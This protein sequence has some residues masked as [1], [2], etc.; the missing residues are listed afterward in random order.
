VSAFEKVWESP[1]GSWQSQLIESW[2]YKSSLLDARSPLVEEGQI[3]EYLCWVGHNSSMFERNVPHVYF[4]VENG[5]MPVTAASF[6]TSS[7]CSF[8]EYASRVLREHGS[9]STLLYIR[10]PQLQ[11]TRLRYEVESLLA[12]IWIFGRRWQ[13]LELEIYVGEYEWTKIGIHREACANI[14]QVI[15]GEK[16]M[17]VWPPHALL[18]REDRPQCALHGSFEEAVNYGVLDRPDCVRIK[19]AAGQAIYIPSAYWHVGLSKRFSVAVNLCL[20]GTSER[21]DA[22]KYTAFGN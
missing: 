18:P 13:H 21:G 14:H 4:A 22:S 2:E 10:N 17:L 19:A 12:P 3:F 8:E 15:R 11:S 16:E 20:Y 5:E 9:K 7:D 6:P 1:I